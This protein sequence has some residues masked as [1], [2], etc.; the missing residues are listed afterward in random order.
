MQERKTDTFDEWRTIVGTF[1]TNCMILA[2]IFNQ[3]SFTTRNF[4]FSHSV[5]QKQNKVCQ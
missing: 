1:W 4:D 2:V 5:V 3:Q